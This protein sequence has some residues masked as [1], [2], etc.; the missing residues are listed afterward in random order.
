MFTRGD[1]WGR[2]TISRP[3]LGLGHWEELGPPVWKTWKKR[4]QVLMQKL[5]R[6]FSTFLLLLTWDSCSVGALCHVK[7][8]FSTYFPH[9]V[10]YILQGIAIF[11]CLRVKQWHILEGET[12]KMLFSLHTCLMQHYFYKPVLHLERQVTCFHSC[13]IIHTKFFGVIVLTWI[14]YCEYNFQQLRYRKCN[15]A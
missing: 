4:N 15:E 9:I 3:A 5:L 10:E 11:R 14:S 2:G 13:W 6:F 1:N 8:C 12:G 7:S